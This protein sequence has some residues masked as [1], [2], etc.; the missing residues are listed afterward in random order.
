MTTVR[1]DLGKKIPYDGNLD[2]VKGVLNA[3]NSD[4]LEEG[5]DIILRNDAPPGSGLGTSSAVMVALIGLLMKYR[6]FSWD[7]YEISAKA[8][9]IERVELGIK[10]GLQDQY[11]ATFGGFNLIEFYKDAVVVNPLNL[12]KD[13][14]NEL[15]LNLILC[16][17]GK[18]RVSEKIIDTQVKNY[19]DKK[20]ETVRAMDELKELTL[21]MKKALLLGKID[22][23]GELLHRAWTNKKKLAD[24]I[25]N[26][27]ID[28][29]YEVALSAGALGGKVLGAGGGGYILIYSPFS[30]KH[31]VI[32]ALQNAGG[33]CVPFCFELQGLQT[34]RI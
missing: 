26:P 19:L 22:D 20:V 32:E 2:L 31:K 14:V 18:T 9:Q 12:N 27:Q 24:Q 29:L 10:G 28:E 23:F 17:T 3:I 25:T 1:Y 4:N 8:V 16:F 5:F 34:W 33:Q 7:N 11:A 13:Y 6:N 30:I 15:E 21:A